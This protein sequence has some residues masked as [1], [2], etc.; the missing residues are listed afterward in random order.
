M[1]FLQVEANPVSTD[2]D[3]LQLSICP[4]TLDIEK[5]TEAGRRKNSVTTLVGELCGRRK[6][7]LAYPITGLPW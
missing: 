2:S 1:H 4:A 7:L 6:V 3:P 5:C